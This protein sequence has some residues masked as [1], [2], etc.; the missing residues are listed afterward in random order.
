MLRRT[1]RILLVAVLMFSIGLHWVVLQSTAWA[2]MIVSY[3]IQEGSLLT[4]VSQT[5]DNEHP[6]PLCC[7][8]KQGKQS[9]KKDTKQADQKKKI[10]LTLLATPVICLTPPVPSLQ[11]VEWIEHGSHFQQRPPS[12]PPRR[13]GITV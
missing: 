13:G 6:C 12:P 7:A 1:A 2:G 4:G 11:R 8:I 10:D 5:F 3:S 9:E